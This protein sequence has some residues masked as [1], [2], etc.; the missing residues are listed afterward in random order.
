MT[1]RLVYVRRVNQDDHPSRRVV[2]KAVFDARPCDGRSFPLATGFATR[3]MSLKCL[4]ESGRRSEVLVHYKSVD[5][6]QS[7]MSECPVQTPDDLET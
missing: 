2:P 1:G 5:V 6:A 4:A 7:W 3:A